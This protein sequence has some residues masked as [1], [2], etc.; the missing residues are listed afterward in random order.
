VKLLYAP[1]GA[2]SANITELLAQPTV[3]VQWHTRLRWSDVVLIR[4]LNR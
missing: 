3:Q 4:D 2:Q 1:H